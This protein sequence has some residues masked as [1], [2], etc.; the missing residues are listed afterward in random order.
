M[1]Y[2]VTVGYESDQVDREGNPRIK[3]VKYVVEG[4]SIEEVNLVMA[5]YRKGDRRMSESYSIAKM[6]IDSVIS[7]ESHPECYKPKQ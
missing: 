5:H 2:L 3:K 1:Y 4:E 7:E 6:S